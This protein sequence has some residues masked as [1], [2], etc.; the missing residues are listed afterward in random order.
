MKEKTSLG[1]SHWGGVAYY[2]WRDYFL[3]ALM[4]WS[5][6]F[7]RFRI[8]PGSFH[9]KNPSLLVW[10]IAIVGLLFFAFAF[11]RR[12][13]REEVSID[14]E[15]GQVIKR[16]DLGG[17]EQVVQL[18][19]LES[20]VGVAQAGA[21]FSLRGNQEPQP[22]GYLILKKGRIVP[23]SQGEDSAGES[24]LKELAESLD[25]AFHAGTVNQKIS[26]T[27]DGQ[28]VFSPHSRQ[29]AV[30]RSILFPSL[31]VAVFGFYANLAL[32]LKFIIF[33]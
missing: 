20:I 5:C 25:V 23:F 15:R 31:C 8:G 29:L 33:N 4:I 18:A 6:L 32:L 3:L 28:V 19:N 27:E 12:W 1:S 26:L 2:R 24:K 17:V 10:I 13:V 7:L 30:F 9:T 11:F 16:R 22:V 21:D 14:Y